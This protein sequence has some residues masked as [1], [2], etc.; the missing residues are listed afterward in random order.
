MSEEKYSRRPAIDSSVA[1]ILDSMQR[2]M[3]TSQLPKKK[4]EQV[5]KERAKIEAR[6]DQRV[7][8]DLPH[9]LKE[10]IRD[11]AEEHNLPASQLATLALIRFLEDMDHGKIDL[12]SMKVA[13]RS[14]RYDWNL[15]LS[16]PNI[17]IEDIRNK[18]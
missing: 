16:S 9:L 1:E 10:K 17:F 15:K 2:K 6:R 4:R 14:P 18:R 11:M 3:A 12:E 8:Y 13:S 7:T 5:V